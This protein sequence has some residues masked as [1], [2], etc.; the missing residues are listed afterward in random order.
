MRLNI[1]WEELG[2]HIDFQDYVDLRFG[3]DLVCR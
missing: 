2:K 3:A 1:L